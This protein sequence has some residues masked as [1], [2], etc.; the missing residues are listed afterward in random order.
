LREG[1]QKTTPELR[2]KDHVAMAFGTP[3]VAY[4]WAESKQ[5]RRESPPSSPCWM[6]PL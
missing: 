1:G 6:V 4:W 5:R 3:V 2:L